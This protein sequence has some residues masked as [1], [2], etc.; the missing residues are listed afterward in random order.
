L[1]RRDEIERIGSDLFDEI[2]TLGGKSR[3]FYIMLGNASSAKMVFSKS[4][5]GRGL[6]FIFTGIG[7]FTYRRRN[8]ALRVA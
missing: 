6:F 1:R 2:P 8:A 7:F 4:P 5:P 3:I